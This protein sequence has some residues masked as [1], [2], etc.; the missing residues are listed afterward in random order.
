MRSA[1]D[2][3]WLKEHFP[4]DYAEMFGEEPPEEVPDREPTV[5][6]IMKRPPLGPPRPVEEE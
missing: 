4:K 2:Q 3:M 6:E 1:D 5:E